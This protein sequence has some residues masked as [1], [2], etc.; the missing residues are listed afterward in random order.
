M[1]SWSLDVRIAGRQSSSIAHGV[2]W[3]GRI[4][5]VFLRDALAIRGKDRVSIPS[6]F[7][8]P[9]SHSAVDI[10]TATPLPVNLLGARP[11]LSIV[12]EH[13]GPGPYRAKLSRTVSPDNQASA[14]GSPV[15]GE[16]GY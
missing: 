5:S 8:D 14:A 6:A 9:K 16:S 2:K 10:A 7:T 15:D 3:D 4:W 12:A 13:L 1:P 11:G